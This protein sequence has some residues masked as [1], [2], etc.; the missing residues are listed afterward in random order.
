MTSR[1][2]PTAS[3]ASH[4]SPA[5]SAA[6]GRPEGS[7][8]SSRGRRRRGASI[9]AVLD[10][11]EIASSGLRNPV[12]ALKLLATAADN[13]KENTEGEEARLGK[14]A[15]SPTS[16]AP[17][18]AVE[19]QEPAE[20]GVDSSAS[21]FSQHWAPSSLD[22]YPLVANKV[23]NAASIGRL[24]SHFFARMHA[25]IP[26]VPVH[27]IPDFY[28]E[29]SLA[30]FVYEEGP[31]AT[32]LLTIASRYDKDYDMEHHSKIWAYMQTLIADIIM[33]KQASIS[34]VEALLILSGKLALYS[35]APIADSTAEYLPKQH[36][37]SAVDLSAE[38]NQMSWMLV[39]NVG[40]A[41]ST[42]GHATEPRR[43]QAVRLGY[44]LGLDQKSMSANTTGDRERI[45]WTCERVSSRI[46]VAHALT[47]P[48]DCYLFD[49]Q[50]AIRNGSAFWSRGE[51]IR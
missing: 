19:Q 45:A 30:R 33:G 41:F 39:G 50:G 12:D 25:A 10:T 11:D 43:E 15:T 13:G 27:K 36:V 4:N 1:A 3:P 24:L 5:T 31:L 35:H 51:R 22:F 6:S 8:I 17:P 20:H 2:P 40:L 38:E 21:D 37:T 16:G 7:S 34:G 14:R 42:S 29:P 28:D 47:P 18:S 48:S 9:G 46:V 26:I 44:F 32:S 49:R 23:L